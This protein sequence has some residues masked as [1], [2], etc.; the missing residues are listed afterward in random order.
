V[1]LEGAVT[2]FEDPDG[3][4]GVMPAVFLGSPYRW[5]HVDQPPAFGGRATF[6]WN[7][8]DRD[9]FEV[10]GTWYGATEATDRQNGVFHFDP[11]GGVSVPAFA[12][13]ANEMSLWGLELNWTRPIAAGTAD[14]PRWRLGGGLRFLRMDEEASLAS[15]APGLGFGGSPFVRS[16]VSNQLL[17]AQ[18]VGEV[19]QHLGG[20]WYAQVD[21]KGFVGSNQRDALVEDE[22]VL[23]GGRHASS[24]ETSEFTWGFEVGAGFVYHVSRTVSVTAS[25]NL[26]FI[27]DASRANLAMDFGQAGS[28]A[29]QAGR[30]TENMITQMF[31]VGVHFRF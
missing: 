1:V 13:L 11:G 21:L 2:F 30:S 25:Y 29:V 27:D 15:F 12:T 3:I 31:L 18:V 19:S 16:E 20:C 6:R 10:R 5:D 14:C 28:G 17:A 8:S 23:S 26:L 24:D 7:P 9:R 22:A 4:V